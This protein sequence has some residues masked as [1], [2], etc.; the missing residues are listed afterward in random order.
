M[1]FFKKRPTYRSSQYFRGFTDYHCHILPG[2]DDGVA[3]LD[4]SLQ[5]LSDYE[6]LGITTVWLTPHVMEDIPNTTAALQQRFGELCDA[7][8]GPIALHLA[9]EYM[10]DTVFDQRLAASDLLTLGDE[11]NQVLVETSY[12]NPPLNLEATLRDIMSHGL[13][14]VLAHP[15]RYRYMPDMDAY[16]RLRQM[17]VRFQLN[18]GSV[19]GIYGHTAQ[20]KALD[21]LK[22]HAYDL[23]GTD[24]HR[25]HQLADMLDARLPETMNI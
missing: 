20:R 19:A 9:A 7:Y 11:G 12:F 13:F 17:G 10:L 2:V 16:R 8:Q 15:E 22:E 14:P 3:E 21:L 5:I 24:L 1:F 23:S 25:R 4:Q 18:H 6:Q